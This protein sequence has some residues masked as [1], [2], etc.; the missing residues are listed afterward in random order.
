MSV[1]REK[2]LAGIRVES[3]DHKVLL[4]RFC[5]LIDR[6]IKQ[7]T[8]EFTYFVSPDLLGDFFHILTFTRDVAYSVFGGYK[9]AEYVLVAV[10][11]DYIPMVADEAFP[12]D[13]LVIEAGRQ[14]S[15][16]E[17]RDILGSLMALGF[18]R[19]RMGD[20][21][22]LEDRAQV[23]ILNDMADY[24][25]TSLSSVGRNKVTVHRESLS[26]FM[27]KPVTYKEM[28]TTVKSVRLDA[29]IASAYNLSRSKA[30]DLVNAKRV[31]VN[32]RPVQSTSK[33]L[34]EGDMVSV[35]GQGRFILES[36]L[37]RTKKDRI[38]IIIKK[39]V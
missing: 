18:S 2:A 7:H 1:N 11:P 24:A 19:E 5:D 15:E 20:I 30:S 10:H 9:E 4:S 27:E 31:K 25:V 34:H 13:M 29:I 36:I 32:Y 23:M 28:A 16:I 8:T 22:L 3:S 12:I 17:H 39:V 14:Q 35:R 33:E 38:K 26:A 21:V 6:V 37:D